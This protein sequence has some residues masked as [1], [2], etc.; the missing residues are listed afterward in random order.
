MESRRQERALAMD[1]VGRLAEIQQEM[2]TLE[3][4]HG[5]TDGLR[6]RSF[7]IDY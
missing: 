2:Q 4:A 1:I 7:S 3:N 6:G 5:S